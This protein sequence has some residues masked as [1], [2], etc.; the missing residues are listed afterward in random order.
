MLPKQ[1]VLLK[2]ISINGSLFTLSRRG[3]TPSQ[4]AILIQEQ[5]DCGNIVTDESGLNL[6]LAGE[7][8]LQQY[9]KSEDCKKKDTWILPQDYYRTNP[10][11]KFD[12]VLPPKQI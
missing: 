10:I 2:I 3:L 9:F 5:I 7:K 8:Y 12:I 11:S 1:I 4:I 6:T